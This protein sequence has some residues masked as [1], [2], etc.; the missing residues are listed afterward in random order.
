M[1][2]FFFIILAMNALIRPIKNLNNSELCLSSVWECVGTYSSNGDY[3]K[4]CQKKCLNN[5]AHKCN[6]EGICSINTNEN[7]NKLI[8]INSLSYCHDSKLKFLNNQMSLQRACKY[9][10][11]FIL[12]HVILFYF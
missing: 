7:C 11:S 9:Y 12:V 1:F 10:F 4:E 8:D 6:E 5:Y 2:K 3:K